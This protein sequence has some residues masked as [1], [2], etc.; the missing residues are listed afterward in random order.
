MFKTRLAQWG[1][2]KKMRDVDWQAVAVLHKQRKKSGQKPSA[3]KVHSRKIKLAD[4]R[5]YLKDRKIS[6][7]DLLAEATANDITSQNIPDH[8]RCFTPLATTDPASPVPDST[9]DSSAS[10]RSPA[11]RP[12][13][14]THC[15]SASPAMSASA[16][17]EPFEFIESHRSTSSEAANNDMS[18]SGPAGANAQSSSEHLVQIGC[19]TAVHG[20]APLETDASFC[21]QVQQNLGLL[22]ARGLTPDS[23]DLSSGATTIEPWT[24]LNPPDDTGS[25]S[26]LCSKCHTQISSHLPFPSDFLLG[27]EHFMPRSMFFHDVHLTSPISQEADLG[28]IWMACCFGAC[29]FVR[30]QDF[31]YVA[32]SLSR[33][34]AAFAQM[35]RTQNSAL[36]TSLN[37]VLTILHAH[38]Q[39]KMAMSVIRSA[40]HVAQTLLGRDDPISVTIEWMTAL[41]W[42]QLG[43]CRVTSDHLREIY[44]QFC[45]FYGIRHPHTLAISYNLAFNLIRDT[46]FEEAEA[47]LRQLCEDSKLTLGPS[48]LQTLTAFA[49]LSR[50]LSNQKKFDEAVKFRKQAIDIGRRT[51]GPNHPHQLESLRR[52]ALIY[53]EQGQDELMEPIY[54]AVLEGRIKCLGPK[55]DFTEGAMEDLI[56]LL[57][58]L[59]KWDDGGEMKRTIDELMARGDETSSDHE[60]F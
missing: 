60:A 47:H 26:V 23:L 30:Q 55:H 4:L 43:Q 8:I 56:E 12:L 3:F 41:M 32:K 59:G 40:L 6:E 24:F 37:S 19:N 39:G 49:T 18:I 27:K 38:D 57:K 17:S 13:D 44:Q 9:Q 5:K 58:K 31:D 14:K 42:K 48:H 20:L 53:K 10:D 33:A 1:Y 46:L 25:P 50:A 11:R 36:L 7:E 2:L 51:L 52:L 35:L 15:G 54:W 45:S 22:C 16:R 29:I 28:S 34:D 21:D